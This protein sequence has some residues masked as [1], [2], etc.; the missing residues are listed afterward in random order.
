[1]TVAALMNSPNTSSSGL[2][3]GRRRMQEIAAEDEVEVR[4]LVAA[5]LALLGREPT[6]DDRLFAE[7]IAVTATRARRL[8]ARGKSDL[9]ER[10]LLTQ[11]FRASGWRP[12]PP[13]PPKQLS[14]AEQIAALSGKPPPDSAADDDD[15]I[16]QDDA[17]EETAS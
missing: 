5:R 7:M 15:D 4:R 17:A 13:E 14:I 11:L 9:D 6:E 2:A 12:S 16:D 10:R 1:M 3:R 8:R